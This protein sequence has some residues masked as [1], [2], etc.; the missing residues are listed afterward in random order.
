MTMNNDHHYYDL[1][2]VSCLIDT[3]SQHVTHM[4]VSVSLITT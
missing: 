2:D 3:H 4:H 1:I